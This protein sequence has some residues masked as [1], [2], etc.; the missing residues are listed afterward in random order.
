MTKLKIPLYQGMIGFVTLIAAAC[1][2]DH[3][4]VPDEVRGYKPIY[5]SNG[6]STKVQLLSPRKI[7]Q[8]GKI[9][10]K[11][12][13]IFL[14]EKGEGVHVIN[15]ADPTNPIVQSFIDIPGNIEIAIKEDVLY[16]NNMSDLIAL[17]IDEIERIKVVQRI[18]NV[19]P[20]ESIGI[21]EGV[22][23]YFECP[24]ETKGAIIG[25]ELATLK[26]PKCRTTR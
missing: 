1:S 8:P 5:L 11:D 19:F 21:P 22:N 13:F 14:N 24:D 23:V 2:I 16:A 18:E 25:W 9:Y 3:D 10:Y 12:G 4:I 20:V 26:S 7:E 6:E 15:N 17:K